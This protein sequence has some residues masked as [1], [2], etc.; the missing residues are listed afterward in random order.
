MSL[1]QHNLTT[2]SITNCTQ[3]TTMEVPYPCLEPKRRVERWWNEL[4]NCFYFR[5]ERI[6][7]CHNG[8]EEVSHTLSGIFIRRGVATLCFNQNEAKCKTYWQLSA[9]KLSSRCPPA[10]GAIR[11]KMLLA[12]QRE[13]FTGS[14]SPGSW[15]S[16]NYVLSRHQRPPQ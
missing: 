14:I 7:N 12:A 13:L 1:P 10:V 9:I 8:T 3:T 15:N 6:F 5:P 11:K 4:T 16:H 2:T